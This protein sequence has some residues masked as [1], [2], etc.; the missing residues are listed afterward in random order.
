MVNGSG[1]SGGQ[2]QYTA[3]QQQY[4]AEQAQYTADAG[5]RD[6]GQPQP[7]LSADAGHAAP[8]IDSASTGAVEMASAAPWVGDVLPDTTSS[9]GHVQGDAYGQQQ[10]QQQQQQAQGVVYGSNQAQP[11]QARPNRLA[12]ALGGAAIAKIGGSGQKPTGGAPVAK[13]EGGGGAPP[14]QQAAVNKSLN[15]NAAKGRGKTQAE[16][17]EE[18]RRLLAEQRQNMPGNDGMA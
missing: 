13:Q 1:Y 17:D 18:Q 2:Q 3:D 14:P 6:L 8:L 7:Q 16:L 12:D 10:Q 4:R 5:H 11:Q 9:H 15:P